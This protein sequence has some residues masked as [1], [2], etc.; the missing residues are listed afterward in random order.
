MNPTPDA[1]PSCTLLLENALRYMEKNVSPAKHVYCGFIIGQMEKV[2]LG[3]CP[4]A[5]FNIPLDDYGLR[6]FIR[7]VAPNYRLAVDG[8]DYELC[9]HPTSREIW[10]WRQSRP[11][12]GEKVKL[13]KQLMESENPADRSEEAGHMLRGLLCGIPMNELDPHWNPQR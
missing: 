9:S 12:V 4:A 3:A 7:D 6:A 10:V 13:A 1:P 2:Y 11:E 5:M 8:S